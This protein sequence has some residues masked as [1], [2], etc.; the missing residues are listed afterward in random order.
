MARAKRFPARG[1][2]FSIAAC[3][4][5][6]QRPE[7]YCGIALASPTNPG[8][9]IGLSRTHGNRIMAQ[10]SEGYVT[11]VEYI[12]DCFPELAPGASERGTPAPRHC[13]PETHERFSYLELG[14]GQGVTLAM[15]AATQ[16]QGCFFGNDF[17]PS[18]AARRPRPRRSANSTT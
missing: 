7:G 13:L 11:E 1:N 6:S 8:N 18:H 9:M 17:N 2:T 4:A 15:L 14:F 10:W 3:A 5:Q 12:A 16:P